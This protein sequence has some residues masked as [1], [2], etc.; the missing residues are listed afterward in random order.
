MSA[1][2]HVPPAL[3]PVTMD[4]P[5]SPSEPS[6]NASNT[7]SKPS[8]PAGSQTAHAVVS[9]TR[10]FWIAT[11]CRPDGTGGPLVSLQ[12]KGRFACECERAGGGNSDEGMIQGR[13]NCARDATPPLSQQGDRDIGG[14]TIRGDHR[15][16]I[17]TDKF[18]IVCTRT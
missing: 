14:S 11:G 7:F 12:Q 8:R 9:R 17:S 2:L 6:G 16:K 3:P 18:G 5:Q 15:K 13:G 10:A 1:Q 4:G